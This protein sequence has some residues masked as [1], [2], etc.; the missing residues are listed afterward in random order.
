MTFKKQLVLGYGLLLCLTLPVVTYG[1]SCHLQ[2]VCLYALLVVLISAALSL[3]ML[4]EVNRRQRQFNTDVAHELRTPLT[5]LRGTLEALLDGV[6][7]PTPE[8][9]ASCH[10]EIGRLTKLVEDLSLLT[11]IEWEYIKLNKTDFDLADLLKETASRFQA[12][13]LQKGLALEL[14]VQSQAIR[15]DYDRLGQVFSNILSNAIKYTD[16]GSVTIRNAGK[17]VFVAD[18]GMGIPPD[19]LPHIF[20][21]FYRSD[22][23]R[24]RS[25]GGS[26]IGLTIAAALV[27]AHGGAIH[28]ESETGKGSVFRVRF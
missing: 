9:L 25:T 19:A 4:R 1:L 11:N 22:G 13:A 26:G 28:A 20:E 7:E 16:A 8:R 5:S 10:E 21:R 15:A 12:A 23:S 14:D 6:W 27:K 18:T 2:W 24:A 3:V 17:E